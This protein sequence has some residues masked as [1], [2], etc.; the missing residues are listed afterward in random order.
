MHPTSGYTGTEEIAN[1]VIHG[2][3]LLLAIAGLAVAV[4]LAS[5]H[6]NAAMIVD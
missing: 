2:I 1:S 6:R 5:L 4:V 3:G